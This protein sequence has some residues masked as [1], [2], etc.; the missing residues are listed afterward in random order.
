MELPISLKLKKRMHKNIAYAQDIL[1]EELYKVFNDAV[2]HGGTAIWRC[3][4]GNRFS[5]DVDVYMEKDEKK[6]GLF[7]ANLEKLGFKII[8]KRIKENSLYSELD[9]NET[10][11]R[12]EAVFSAIKGT[13]AE[14]ENINGTLRSIYSLNAE[15]FVREKVNTYLKRKKIRDLYDIYFLLKYVKEKK[16]VETEIKTLI[17]NFSNP[18]DEKNLKVILISPPVPSSKVLLEYIER[19]A[20]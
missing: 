7:F 2:L 18:I 9:F 17:I 3:F 6:I 10:R 11:V 14:Y 5:E 16:A 12:F 19:W 13:L 4:K 15:S 1:I 20:R 8:K